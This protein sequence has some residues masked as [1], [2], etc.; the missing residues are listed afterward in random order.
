MANTS[1]SSGPV[2]V[3][4]VV[5]ATVVGLG[6]LLFTTPAAAGPVTGLPSAPGGTVP[7]VQGVPVTMTC[8]YEKRVISSVGTVDSDPMPQ[9]IWVE[10]RRV[11]C[12]QS[13]G[14]WVAASAWQEVRRWAAAPQNDNLWNRLGRRQ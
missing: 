5:L 3:G 7:I 2:L 14:A 13:T 11:L 1:S 12:Q 4:A 6:I 8:R 9:D 10:Q